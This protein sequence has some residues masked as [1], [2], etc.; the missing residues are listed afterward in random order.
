MPK[1]QRRAR[2]AKE[3]ADASCCF[4]DKLRPDAAR[5]GFDGGQQE[6]V[7]HPAVIDF[8]LTKPAGRDDIPQ[9]L[10]RRVGTGRWTPNHVEPARGA[11]NPLNYFNAEQPALRLQAEF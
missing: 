10:A 2:M 5:F 1:K 9:H 3:L 11:A 8:L 6:I 4:F 7:E